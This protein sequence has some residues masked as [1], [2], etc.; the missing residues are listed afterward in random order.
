MKKIPE[1]LAGF[2]I[3][4]QEFTIFAPKNYSYEVHSYY[5]CPMVLLHQRQGTERFNTSEETHVLSSSWVCVGHC[6]T[7]NK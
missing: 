4:S 7:Q 1:S 2:G 6:T 3:L 5:F